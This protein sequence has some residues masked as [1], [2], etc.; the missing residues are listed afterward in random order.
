[1]ELEFV[2]YV[3]STDATPNADNLYLEL[4][5]PVSG[6]VLA[7]VAQVSNTSGANGAWTTSATFDLSGDA[8]LFARR[9]A[10]RLRATTDGSTPTTFYVDNI[11]LRVR[12]IVPKYWSAEYLSL[13]Q[14]FV[15]RLAA[16]ILGTTPFTNIPLDFVSM[17]V[18]M[19]G[20]TQP[21]DGFRYPAM[22]AELEAK[23]LTSS[24]WIDTVK[25]ITD[26]YANVFGGSAGVKPKMNLLLQYAPYYQNVSE[27]KQFTDYAVTR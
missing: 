22:N 3:D 21:V 25:K 17:G 19:Y 16:E 12:H 9:L 14:T 1:M 23:G 15:T 13:Y 26:I 24:G 7:T 2:Y 10:V 5:D 20:E 8:N 27:R 11:K 18:G 4:L 6:D